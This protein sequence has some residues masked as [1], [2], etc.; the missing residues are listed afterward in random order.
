MSRKFVK[1]RRCTI[2]FYCHIPCSVVILCFT[3]HWVQPS[4]FL[5]SDD[6]VTNSLTCNFLAFI[7]LQESFHQIFIFR[8]LNSD[9]QLFPIGQICHLI[10]H[11]DKQQT[12]VYCPV[13]VFLSIFSLACVRECSPATRSVHCLKCIWPSIMHC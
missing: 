10:C 6:G 12:R 1:F 4:I 3:A 13:A 11:H 5:R 9:T 8:V 7:E 2:L